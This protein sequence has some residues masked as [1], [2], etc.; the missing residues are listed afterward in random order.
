MRITFNIHYNTQWGQQIYIVGA[1]SE[2]GNGDT[3]QA[4]CC[5]YLDHGM[6]QAT[7]ELDKTPKVMEYRYLLKN[8]E[9][10]ILDIDWGKDRAFRPQGKGKVAL[11]DSWRSQQHPD[12]IFYTS[13]FSDVLLKSKKYRKKKTPGNKTAPM[14]RFQIRAPRG[15]EGHQ[16]CVCGNIPELGEWTAGNP[17]LLSNTH[18]PIWSGDLLLN[19][20]KIIEYKYGF[21]DPKKK[22]VI[23]LEAGPNRRIAPYQLPQQGALTVV[24]DEYLQDPDGF[25]RGAGIA[26]PV[27]S[28]RSKKGFGVGEFLDLK[29]LADWAAPIGL[30]LLQIL[31]INDTSG[32]N[33]WVDSYPYS[34]L[35]PYALHPLYLHLESMEGD[36]KIL[37]RKELEQKRSQLNK[38]PEVD[39]EAV[40]K[41]K[42][43]YARQIYNHQKKALG[44][45]KKFLK[46]IK[47]NDRWLPAY[48]LFCCRRDEYGTA[49]FNQWKKDAVFS[50][51]R[52]K[53]AT[54]PK[55]K[56]YEEIAFYYFLQYHLDRQLKEASAYIRSKGLILKG[57]IPIGIYRYS[58]DAWTEPHLFNMDGQSGAP[59][60][61]FSDTGQNWGFPTYNWE[62]MAKDGYQWWQNRLK[63]LSTYFDA[64]RIDHILGFFRIWQIPLSQ[65]DGTL[66]FFNP[67][68][69]VHLHE[70]AQRRIGF[71]Y[72]RYCLPY[73]T[74][75]IVERM[76]GKD[77]SYVFDTFLEKSNTGKLQF[78]VAFD[79]Q[80]KIE[81][82]FSKKSPTAYL[83]LKQSLF[84]LVSN[85]LFI[86][87]KDS[88][89]QAFHPRIEFQ[90]TE[91]FKALDPI[92][93]HALVE[94]YNDYFYHRQEDFWQKRAMTIL[95]VLKNATNMMICGEDLGMVPD[96]VPDVM[97]QLNILTLE[98][99]RMSKNPKT[100]FLQAR[101]I[102]YLSIMSPS[103]HDMDTVRLWWE[104]MDAEDRA[105]FHLEEIGRHT[106]PPSE[107]NVY[108]AEAILRQHLS[109]PGMW[110]VFSIQDLMAI[111][112]KLRRKDASAERINVPANPQHYWRYRFHIDLEDLMV[113][114]DFNHRITALIRSYGRV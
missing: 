54:Q 47:D 36:A 12:N 109:W 107:G 72:E 19:S 50:A 30:K 15:K 39:Y 85:V 110:A 73:I 41:H 48:A 78:K 38:L 40:M 1:I 63:Q 11:Y 62:E 3:S 61:P 106:P 77:S 55:A 56:E 65:V 2:L 112:P 44:K 113:T 42:I 43:A 10:T 53:E 28:L 94:L 4:L 108:I 58:V 70:F 69:P 64:F 46:F 111:D 17:L 86:E 52:L 91:S 49:D 13:A 101:D 100:R 26:I 103:T 84:N 22:K 96:C 114:Q 14:L 32:T 20:E 7:I 68:L 21:F 76:F 82:F 75:D 80:R 89:G 8:D 74:E 59:P 34:C 90:K 57:D 33:T 99:Q 45:D 37:N 104:A 9:G 93:Q 35:S 51:K 23:A 25:W 71:N 81:N 87:V 18:A 29:S 16:I 27:F 88:D 98:I 66:G 6:W 31:P 5:T 24:T 105:K 97:H 92:T 95:P 79:T 102:P 67:A 83:H 60:D